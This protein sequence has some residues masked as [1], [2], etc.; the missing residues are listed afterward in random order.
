M[1]VFKAI[2]VVIMWALYFGFMQVL[3]PVLNNS[4]A[5]SQMSIDSGAY[6]IFAGW[7]WL[8]S[9]VPVILVAVTIL[10]F[11]KEI[12]KLYIKIKNKIKEIDQ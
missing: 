6:T 12:K 9:L 5:M 3:Y 4:V 8:G 11:L 10:I 1:K 2:I 7:Q